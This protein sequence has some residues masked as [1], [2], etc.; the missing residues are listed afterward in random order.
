[1]SM[2]REQ[3]GHP[4]QL[5]VGAASGG[6]VSVSHAERPAAS[7]HS[8]PIHRAEEMDVCRS[9]LKIR[10]ELFRE[11]RFRSFHFAVVFIDIQLARYFDRAYSE[12]K[13][14]VTAT[15]VPEP[16]NNPVPQGT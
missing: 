12:Y 4:S 2:N 6:P 10:V 8:A 14:A 5:R 1:M 11:F 7:T 9:S 16:G 13:G 15:R 3:S